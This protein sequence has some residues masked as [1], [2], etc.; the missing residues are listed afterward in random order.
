MPVYEYHC[1]SCGKRIEKIQKFSDPPLKQCEVCGGT[2]KKILSAP[3]LVFK[4]TGWY[5]TDYGGKK[6]EKEKSAAGGDQS[7]KE[8]A[9]D[10]GTSPTPSTTTSPSPQPKKDTPQ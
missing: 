1:Q 5:V 8:K 6:Q 7:S 10:T 9:K 4:G 3:A 2:L